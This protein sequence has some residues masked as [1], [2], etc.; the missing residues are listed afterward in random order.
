[1]IL[2][3][4]VI[5]E[6]LYAEL[7][8]RRSAIARPIRLGILVSDPTPVIE[9]FVKIKSH[10]ATRLSVDIVRVD[11]PE[12]ASTQEAQRI[13]RET[14][15][16][17]DAVIVQLPLS[18]NL[19]T[20]VVLA[21][22]PPDKDVDGISLAGTAERI[23]VAPVARA[24]AYMLAYADVQVAGKKVVVLGG[25]RLVGAPT[26]SLLRSLGG[27]VSSITLEQGSM[28]ELQDADII[29]C[30]AGKPGL[31]QPEH[32]K[33]GVVIVDAGTSEQGGVV[34]GDADS[35]C[36]EKASVF[37]PVPGGVGPVAVAM[38]FSNLLDLVEKR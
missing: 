22:I 17:A 2:D 13:V 10:V 12:G 14:A 3:G 21:A 38:I 36:A 6:K 25:G 18:K 1:M 31:V 5:A 20:D 33:D 29:V 11:V 30:G 7:L 35:A 37:T 19:D 16:Q 15:A 34:R 9:S 32:I 8:E 4:K 23:V 27:V 28:E 26:A 24:V